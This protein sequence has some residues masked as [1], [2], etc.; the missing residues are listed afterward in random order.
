MKMKVAAAKEKKNTLMIHN[1]AAVCD[2]IGK[3][4]KKATAEQNRATVSDKNEKC[5]K[6]AVT[7]VENVAKENEKKTL[8]AQSQTA[9]EVYCIFCAE[10]FEHPPTEE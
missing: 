2:E 3:R 4:S 8:E 1:I 9:E 7:Q 5:T 10:L 6:T